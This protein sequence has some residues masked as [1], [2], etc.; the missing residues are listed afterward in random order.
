M[1]SSNEPST[2]HAETIAEQNEK[3]WDRWSWLTLAAGLVLLLLPLFAALVSLRYPTDGWDSTAI[4]S[5]GISFGITG[6]HRMVDNI[7]GQ[8]S[9]LQS[10]DIVVAIDGHPLTDGS[11]PPVPPDVQVGQTLRYTVKRG[12]QTLDVDVPIL[13]LM[14]ADIPTQLRLDF[15]ENPENVLFSLLVFA[16]A[17]GVFALRPGSLAARYLFLFATFNLGLYLSMSG[18]LLAGLKPSWLSF[19]SQ[20]NGWGWVYVFMPTITLIVLVFPVRK[21]PVRRFPRLTP[22]LL[23]GL[24]LLVSVVANA[25]VWF[26]G[27]LSAA[28]ILLYLT[29]YS[30]GLMLLL[31]PATLIHNLLTIRDPLPQAQ[32]RWIAL[33]FGAGLVM[34]LALMILNFVALGGDDLVTRLGNMTLVS[35]PICL[36]IGIL[37]YRLFDIDVIIRRTTSYAIITGLLALIYFGSIVILQR[38]LSPITGES[39]PA[40]VISTLI[41]YALFQP[42]RRRVQDVIDRRFNR[43]RYN[44]EKTIEAFA[45]TVRNET[46]L[47]ALT[48]ELLRVIQQT[49]EPESLSIVLFD[50]AAEEQRSKVKGERNSVR[51]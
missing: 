2:T 7:S 20:L 47:E 26:G 19:L 32:M 42:I 25:A 4:G 45:A 9:A 43:S 38:L 27:Y 23:I 5:A 6:P 16:V 12:N 30:I 8:P 35:M 15:K 1:S 17:V 34:P 48:A 51:Y 31:A 50:R 28:E 44:A 18:G 22:F 13:R 29:V 37:R 3:R 14:P 33:G 46:D 36:A 11:L 40:V 41:I 49:M 10:E 21:W 39:T 24:P